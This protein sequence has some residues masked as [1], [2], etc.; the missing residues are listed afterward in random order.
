MSVVCIAI[1]VLEVF[2]NFYVHKLKEL[3]KIILQDSN[4]WMWI[5]KFQQ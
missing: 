5:S 4:N 3:K 2:E 1:N